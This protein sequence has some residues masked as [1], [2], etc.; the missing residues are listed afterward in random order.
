MLL[1]HGHRRC[2]GLSVSCYKAKYY[3]KIPFQLDASFQNSNETY[4]PP[5]KH[6]IQLLQYSCCL[7]HV[8]QSHK[9][10]PAFAFHIGTSL[11]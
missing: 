11:L 8:Y 3:L 9:C 5:M 4:L 2:I 1:D 6:I 10:V 7:L